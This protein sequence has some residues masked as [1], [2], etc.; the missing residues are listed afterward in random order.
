MNKKIDREEVL[1]IL[2]NEIIEW[3]YLQAELKRKLGQSAS[4]ETCKVV[5]QTIKN[6]IEKIRSIN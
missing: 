4:E 3:D 6:I 1:E 5:R 2:T